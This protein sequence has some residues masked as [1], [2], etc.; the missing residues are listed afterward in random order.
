MEDHKKSLDE[1]NKQS[2]EKFEEYLKDRSDIK[3]D[4]HDKINQAKKEWQE[5]YQKL[6]DVAMVLDSFEI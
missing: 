4:Q 3:K 6:V 2:L 1:L 5:A